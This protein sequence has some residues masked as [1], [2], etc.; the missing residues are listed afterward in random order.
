MMSID[1]LS[2]TEGVIHL[3]IKMKIILK[4]ESVNTVKDIPLELEL[5]H[6][7]YLKE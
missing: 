4:Y 1:N 6:S 7:N 2:F 5:A 3:E